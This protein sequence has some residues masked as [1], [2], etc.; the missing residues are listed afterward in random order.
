[1]SE[2]D[3]AKLL[4][5]WFPELAGR[6]LNQVRWAEIEPHRDYAK[7]LLKTTTVTTIHQRM[8][9]EGKLKV[10]L[11]TFRCW[12]H[13]NLPD[14]AARSK[15]TVLREDVEP[16]SEA[17]IDYGFLGQWINPAG[18][19]RHRIWAFA[20]V[21]PASRHMFVRPVLHMGQHA[22]TLAHVEAFRFFGG[23]PRR[24]V[25][26]NLKTGVDK[27]DL[28]DPQI[29]KSYAELASYCGTS[30][31]PARASKPKGKPRVERPMPYVRDSF[32]SGRTFTSLEHMQAEALLWARNVAGQRQ[33]RPL[34]GA[35][36]LSVFEAVE[37][38]ALLPLPPEPFVPVRWSTAMVGPDIHVKVG[39]LKTLRLSGMLETLDAR[40]TQAQKGELGHLDFLQVLCQDEISRRETVALERRLRKAKFEQQAALEGSGFHASP[41][42]PAAQI[43]DLAALRRLHSGDSVILFGPVGVG[44]THVAQALG[45]QAVRQGANVRFTKTSRAL[46]ELAGGHADRTWDKRMRE[47]VRPDLLILDDFAM[48]Q[49]TAPQA[50]D[51]YELVSER[52]G[53]PLTITSNRAPSDWY[54]LFRTLSLRSGHLFVSLCGECQ[55][56]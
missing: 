24:L 33:C 2:T 27:P 19:K 11:S 15:A 25:P 46:A 14:E 7:E 20:M 47:L 41:K 44:K 42:L 5:R 1:M 13:E 29:N 16:G 34:D 38:E 52:Q 54:P 49:L 51:L 26:D 12:V 32:W 53:R 35:K 48:R 39:S 40:L 36:P 28:Y 6:K 4:K 23:V 30:V 9:Y 56:S 17:Q 43:R 31:D 45:H 3:W 50:D 8:W 18:G 22:W 55:G 21:L 37:A 10:S